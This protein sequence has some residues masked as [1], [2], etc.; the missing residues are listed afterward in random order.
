MKV[1]R[2]KRC[3]FVPA[4]GLEEGEEGISDIQH[5]MVVGSDGPLCILSWSY[6]GLGMLSN[7][8]EMY[9]QKDL[10]SEQWFELLQDLP[11]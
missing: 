9:S 7:A 2:R 4:V 6:P 3:N 10:L 1:N 11:H 5:S 8:K